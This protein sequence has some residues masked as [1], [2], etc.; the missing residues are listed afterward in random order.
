MLHGGNMKRYVLALMAMLCIAA[1]PLAA[2]ATPFPGLTRYTLDNGLEVF[3][4]E[5]HA[6]PLARIQITFRCGAITQ[7]PETA[8]LFHLYEHLLFKGNSKYKTETEFSA[9]MTDLGVSEWNGGTSTEYVTYYFTVPSS[10]LDAGIEF[11]SWAIREP[12]FD[13]E[14]LAIEK[15]VVVNEINAELGDPD[16]IYNAA[17]NKYMFSK[18]PWRRDVGGF[19]KAIRSATPA[20]MRTIQN[21]YYIPNNAAIFISGDVN[22]K[23]VLEMVKKWFGTWKKGADPWKKPLP[24]HPTPAV[25]KPLYL[26]I[27]DDSLPQG[28]AYMQISYRGPDVL[29]DPAATYAADVWGYLVDNHD[30][31]FKNTINDKV[32]GLYNK[33]YINAYYYTQRDGG[34]IFFSTY[35]FVNQN[36]PMAE[37]ALKYFKP[38]VID[39]VVKSIVSNPNYFARKEYDTVKAIMEDHDLISLEN[40]EGFMS[41]LSFW[42]SVASTDYYFGYVPN[43]KKVTQKEIAAFLTKYVLNNTEI[44]VIRA[45]P[46]DVAAEKK[47]LADAGFITITEENAFWWRDAK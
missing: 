44:I 41:T 46:D 31:A 33:D 43:M 7:T 38:V 13:P 8:G 45:N 26:V 23:T 47:S 24:P 25:T 11:W 3:I 40:P 18:F 30:G 20:V 37:R 12:L 21:T 36:L 17:M 5:N 1:I 19:E 6:V 22:P 4:L 35:F 9:A 34:Q 27:P 2:Q 32:P 39:E 28:I 10:K 42:W 29:A 15:D 16:H 14:E